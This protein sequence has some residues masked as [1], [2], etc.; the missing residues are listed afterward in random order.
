MSRFCLARYALAGVV[1]VGLLPFVAAEE[2]RAAH[3]AVKPADRLSQ[4]WWNDRHEQFLAQT[5]K[6]HIDVVFLGDSITQGWEGAGRKVWDATFKPLRAGNY[7]IGGDQTSHVLWRITAGKELE[8]IK[9]KAAVIMIGT[10]NVGGHSAEQIAEGITAIVKELRH[11]KPHMKI[12]LLGV[13]PRAGARIDKEAPRATA[14]Q[15]QPKIGQINAIIA[16]LDDG[17]MVF[18]KDIGD[19]FLDKDGALPKAIMPDYLHLSPSGYTIWAEAIQDD[20]ARL[21][22]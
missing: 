12:L 13:F 6:G 8:G 5:R 7:G 17:K 16:K 15:L 3:G 19:K 18:Y 11:Q 2:P 4:K 21:V 10:N 20:L 1:V 14:K 9:P 22:K